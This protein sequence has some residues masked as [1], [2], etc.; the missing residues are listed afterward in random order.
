MT[1]TKTVAHPTPL[2]YVKLAVI[3]A[4]LTGI[5]VA[6]F[7]IEDTVGSFTAPLLLILAFLKFV[8]V[9]GYYMHLRYEKPLLY[10]FFTVGFVLAMGCYTVVL[11]TFG[12]IA[13]TAS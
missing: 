11:A 2:L 8:L 4:V 10:R 12:V 7:Y 9:I 13:I 6:L 1:E 5:E 3:L